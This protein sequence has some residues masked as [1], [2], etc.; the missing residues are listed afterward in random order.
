MTRVVIQTHVSVTLYVNRLAWAPYCV[1]SWICHIT[2][3]VIFLLVGL[4]FPYLLRSWHWLFIRYFPTSVLLSYSCGPSSACVTMETIGG[5]SCDK[6]LQLHLTKSIGFHLVVFC[7]MYTMWYMHSNIS[8][9]YSLS[10][11]QHSG[12]HG[13]WSG[14]E[15]RSVSVILESW[16]IAGQSE[17]W[18][19]GMIGLVTSQWA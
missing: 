7:W 12:S 2:R 10:S 18:K 15:E 17:L 9:E 16:R 8:E 19:G 13:Y 1:N 6:G 14:W 11:A 4:Y 5:Y 3:V